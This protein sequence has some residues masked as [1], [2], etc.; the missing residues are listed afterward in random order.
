[1][2]FAAVIR[3]CIVGRDYDGWR[4]ISSRVVVILQR[5]GEGQEEEEEEEG[6]VSGLGT[7]AACV[8]SGLKGR[9][10][11]LRASLASLQS[12]KR[13]DDDVQEKR[14]EVVTMVLGWGGGRGTLRPLS[15]AGD[16]R[17]CWGEMGVGGR[18]Q[19]L[20][21]TCKDLGEAGQEGYDD[22]DYGRGGRR[23]CV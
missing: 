6:L 23:A 18:R 1:M 11:G 13:V 4:A 8:S 5:I 2:K 12:S 16:D 9:G 21:A 22:D 20:R 10:G 19:Q 17:R 14:R 7:A 3:Q 15:R